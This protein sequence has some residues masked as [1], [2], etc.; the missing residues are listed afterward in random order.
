MSYID[1]KGHSTITDEEACM[2]VYQ[3]L[4]ALEYLHG[5]RIAHRDLKPD[6]VLLST[7]G[8]SARVILAD[9]GQSTNCSKSRKGLSKRMKTLCG[10]L[11][12]V[13]PYVIENQSQTTFS[14]FRLFYVVKS[15]A[16][17]L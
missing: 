1:R 15:M 14:K 11:D 4:R 9:F 6:N 12:F 3:I 16:K 8:R 17:I 13:A 5:I 7:T 10:T 2:I